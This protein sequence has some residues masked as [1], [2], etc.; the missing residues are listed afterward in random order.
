MKIRDPHGWRVVL[1]RNVGW[2]RLIISLP[3]WPPPRSILGVI[4]I[5]K[6]FLK[7]NAFWPPGVI[8]VARVAGAAG[9]RHGGRSEGFIDPRQ[10]CSQL[11]R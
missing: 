10:C 5:P 6:D 11:D 9:R 4:D 2:K 3:L 8:T 1:D 7:V